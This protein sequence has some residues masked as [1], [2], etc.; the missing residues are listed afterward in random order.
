M[1]QRS[2]HGVGVERMTDF[3]VLDPVSQLRRKTIV[4]RRLDQQ[5]RRRRAALAV[6]RID[7]ED[8]GIGRALQIGIGEHHHG[9]LAAKLEV[10]TLQRVRALPGNQRAGTALADK[11]DRLDVRVTGQ[12]YAC[13]LAKPVD[14]I[15][16]A[17][18]NSGLLRNLGKQGR[19]QR[20]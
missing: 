20:R 8:R 17:I 7:H 10:H 3:D 13:F 16:D 14:H 15:P 1:D 9:V 12:R 11:A 19:R 4:D 18:R 5:P 2:D 6:Q